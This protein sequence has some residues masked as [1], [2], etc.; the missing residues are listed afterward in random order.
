MMQC[1]MYA[2]KQISSTHSSRCSKDPPCKTTSPSWPIR[3]QLRLGYLLA[4]GTMMNLIFTIK[5]SVNHLIV[6]ITNS[7]ASQVLV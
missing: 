7:L 6:L 3:L 2:L 4:V 5:V 1:M